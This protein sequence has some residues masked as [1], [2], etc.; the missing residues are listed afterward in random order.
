MSDNAKMQ[1]LMKKLLVLQYS[2][3]GHGKTTSIIKTIQD[4]AGL[5][6][7]AHKRPAHIVI[8]AFTN[9]NVNE[10]EFELSAC[11]K[12]PLKPFTF[13]VITLDSFCNRVIG[14]SDGAVSFDD[15]TSEDLAKLF[16]VKLSSK[17]ELC[18]F[19]AHRA[20]PGVNTLGARVKQLVNDAVG[21]RQAKS[22][23]HTAEP[24]LGRRLNHGRQIDLFILDECQDA[25]DVP[26][27]ILM[28]LFLCGKISHVMLF[29]DYMQRIYDSSIH[30]LNNQPGIKCFQ[31]DSQ[32]FLEQVESLLRRSNII[33]DSREVDT[34]QL[35]YKLNSWRLPQG[36]VEEVNKKLPAAGTF[37]QSVIDNFAMIKGMGRAPEAAEQA[38]AV[39]APEQADQAL[40]DPA[41]ELIMGDINLLSPNHKANFP[42]DTLQRYT[43]MNP[44]SRGVVAVYCELYF[45]TLNEVMNLLTNP[46]KHLVRDYQQGKGNKLTIEDSVQSSHGDR[47]ILELVKEKPG[48]LL[49][50]LL[51]AY[52]YSPPTVDKQ[53]RKAHQAT[54]FMVLIKLYYGLLMSGLKVESPTTFDLPALLALKN[55][56]FNPDRLRADEVTIQTARTGEC[57]A[58]F[59]LAGILGLLNKIL[60]VVQPDREATLI[61]LAVVLNDYRIS[62]LR[63]MLDILEMRFGHQIILDICKTLD[64]PVDFILYTTTYKM[65]GGTIAGKYVYFNGKK[66]VFERKDKAVIGNQQHTIDSLKFV[67]LTRSKR[68]GYVINQTGAK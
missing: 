4:F 52:V 10:F 58:S 21:Q 59:V 55:K 49:N 65:K 66:N 61:E 46:G 57:R 42:A 3:A 31:V 22:A 35:E 36:Y 1:A 14:L 51:D 25:K 43:A 39:L 11:Y 30:I 47:L 68:G 29:G 15:T 7:Q 26:R 27:L 5:H 16:S 41:C 9:N 33:V 44:S 67:G 2:T 63:Q 13:E 20:S 45:Q 32:Q 48:S 53:K 28:M 34:R 24:E 56:D 38:F 17:D 37:G 60:Q 6:F 62:T 64:I 50:W 8:T 40:G 18:D 23:G 12:D 54:A 19:F